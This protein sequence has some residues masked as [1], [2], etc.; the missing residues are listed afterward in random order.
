MSQDK[1][2]QENGGEHPRVFIWFSRSI[3]RASLYSRHRPLSKSKDHLY[4]STKALARNRSCKIVGK[5]Y[6]TFCRAHKDGYFSCRSFGDIY[7]VAISLFSWGSEYNWNRQCVFSL[8][9]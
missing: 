9:A 3:Y 8:V 7:L 5:I 6:L 1:E 2:E 4:N